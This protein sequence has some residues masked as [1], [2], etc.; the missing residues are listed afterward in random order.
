MS[1]SAVAT[2][3]FQQPDQFTQQLTGHSLNPL[4][5]TPYFILSAL[6]FPMYFFCHE[7]EELPFISGGPAVLSRS[8]SRSS[9]DRGKEALQGS[10]EMP[11]D[12]AKP[13]LHARM[14]PPPLSSQ[15]RAAIAAVANGMGRGKIYKKKAG[16][17]GCS[18]SSRNI[19]S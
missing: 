12:A 19:T 17:G 3:S 18:I 6:S 14:H 4:S 5:I 13:A 2:R 16:E 1:S 9:G 7:P 10:R 11:R 8:G 15:A